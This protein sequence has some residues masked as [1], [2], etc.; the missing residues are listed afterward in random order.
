MY[1]LLP[2]A[3]A[4][5]SSSYLYEEITSRFCMAL[6]MRMGRYRYVYTGF[7]YSAISGGVV[8][9]LGL[10]SY[11][12]LMGCIFQ[13]SPGYAYGVAAGGMGGMAGA[14]LAMLPRILHMSLYGMAMSLLSSFFV[15][16]YPKLYFDL[17]ILFLVSYLLREAAMKE[18][19]LLPASMI[20][21]LAALYGM[22]WRIR[23]RWA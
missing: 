17:S 16:V 11:F 6:E 2:I 1:L 12:L 3:A 8:V 5:P 4:A 9:A 14:A 10:V 18:A 23:S 13:P 22:V 21:A 15:Y 7:L 20:G 19:F